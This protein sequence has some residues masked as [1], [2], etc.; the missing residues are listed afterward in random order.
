MEK[1]IN[2]IILGVKGVGNT[3]IFNRI[4]H[5]AFDEAK[6][7]SNINDIEYFNLKRKYEK[8]GYCNIIKYKRYKKSR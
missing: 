3:S 8:K 6:D 2:V 7:N 5:G 1:E 4:K